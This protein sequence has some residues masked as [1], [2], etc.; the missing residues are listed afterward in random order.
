[1]MFSIIKKDYL[2]KILAINS[3]HKDIKFTHEEEKDNKLP[4]LDLLIT[5]ESSHFEFEIYRKPT[6]TMRV[7]PSTSNHTYQHKM[8]AFHHM[9]HR[10]QTLP[11]S[12]TGKSKELD[13]IFETA[14]LNG[15]RNSTIQAVVDKRARD[16]YRKSMTTLTAEKED[17]KRVAVNFDT[18]ITQ[19]LAKKFRKYGVDLVF[20][21]RSSQLKSRLGSTKDKINKLNRAGVYKISCPHC[22][23][24]YIGQTKRTLEI[25][26][27]EHISEV[28]KRARK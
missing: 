10:M 27:K 17:L 3:I 15:Y 9:I 26:L 6:N 23:K 5:R 16:K 4:F 21:S 18:K 14:R 13:Y 1:M 22:N 7:I 12:E 20:S 11:L 2:P 19:P 28:E 24:I 25:R 8:A